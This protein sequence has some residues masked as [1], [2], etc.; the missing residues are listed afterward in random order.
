MKRRGFLG[1]MAALVPAGLFAKAAKLAPLHP[2]EPFNPAD[3]IE[4]NITVR[5]I[6]GVGPGA[7]GEVILL[8]DK[9][10]DIIIDGVPAKPDL[11]VLIHEK[12]PHGNGVYNIHTNKQHAGWGKPGEAG[13]GRYI[14][15]AKPGDVYVD[16]SEDQI[17][18][19]AEDGSWFRLMPLCEQER[20][21]DEA[22]RR[23]NA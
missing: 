13:T 16:W 1:F 20:F 12:N 15:D 2:E 6:N 21:F 22:G 17:W 19:M 4:N 18:F 11:K 10:G 5:S 7:E 3:V 23:R 9:N 14:V 8:P